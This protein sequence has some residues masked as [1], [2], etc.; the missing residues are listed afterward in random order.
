MKSISISKQE[1]V[2]EPPLMNAAGML[3]FAPDLH[4]VIDY[5]CLGAFITN[6]ISLRPRMAASAQRINKFPGGLLIHTGYPNPGLNTILKTCASHWSRSPIPII[7]HLLAQDEKQIYKMVS[8]LE[9]L[10]SVEGVEIGFP[11]QVDA[12]LACNMLQAA[13]GE[14]PVIARL[15][16]EEAEN[17]LPVISTRTNVNAV[18]LAP[19]RGI[20]PVSRETM[21][22]GRLYGPNVFPWSLAL[23]QKIAAG[24]LPVVTAGGIYT[25][26]QI[27][28]MLSVG[29]FGVQ[30]DTVLWRSGTKTL[31]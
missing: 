26:E 8:R 30:V 22:E 24:N 18:S 13:A 5:S 31:T 6:P 15:P 1:L 9:G 28:I 29:A 7:V 17:L 25:Q 4:S 3:G 14:L 10:E 12:E 16:F 27:E 21:V 11:S 19:P 20:L 2:I 23:T